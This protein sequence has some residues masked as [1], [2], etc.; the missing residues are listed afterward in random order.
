ML[1]SWG[2][3]VGGGNAQLCCFGHSLEGEWQ[4]AR[5]LSVGFG[6]AE[7]L[8]PSAPSEFSV[9]LRGTPVRSGGNERASTTLEE[10]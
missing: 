8:F 2:G 1:Q 7:L 6:T 4:S 3:G 5:A 9:S 10:P